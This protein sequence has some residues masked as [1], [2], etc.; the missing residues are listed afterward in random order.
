[1]TDSKDKN[2][3]LTEG[4][5]AVAWMNYVSDEVNALL[6][7]FLPLSKEGVVG[8][9]YMPA[10]KE[11]L[12]TGPEHDTSKAS[13]VEIRLVFNFEKDMPTPKKNKTE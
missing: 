2:K 4:E 5:R 11:M 1:M 10:V 6:A 12:E 13:G 9:K 8:I 3:E 7:I